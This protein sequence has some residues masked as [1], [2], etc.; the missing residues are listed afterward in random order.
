MHRIDEKCAAGPSR[1]RTCVGRGT[2]NLRRPERPRRNR[3][4][5]HKDG[6][7]VR[8]RV[9]VRLSGRFWRW[10]WGNKGEAV[11]RSGHGQTEECTERRARR[12]G[13]IPR[14]T[15][16]VKA[17]ATKQTNTTTLSAQARSHNDSRRQCSPR[18]V[19]YQ[20]RVLF[21]HSSLGIE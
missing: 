20:S 1:T 6:R 15:A 14:A 13:D 5:T 12:N 2:S 7:G 11:E 9:P 16:D 17:N 10:W 18:P 4:G 21:I 3:A 8:H 19:Q